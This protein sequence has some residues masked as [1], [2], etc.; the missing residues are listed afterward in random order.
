[1]EAFIGTIL[2]F[3]GNFAP[4]GWALCHGQQ[5]SIQQNAALFSI[6]GTTY[7]GDGVRTFALPDLRGRVAV[8]WGGGPGL[9]PCELGER[10]GAESV[11]LTGAVAVTGS[12][13]ARA[14][15]ANGM[16]HENRQPYLGMNYI[17]ALEGIFPSRE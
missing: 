12:G 17:I 16:P 5:L 15:P 13:E 7:G 11:T 6:L 8:G 9:S 4:R 3:A 2:L 1:M 10:G 14:L